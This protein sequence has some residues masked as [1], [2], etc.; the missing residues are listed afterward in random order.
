[1]FLTVGGSRVGARAESDVER[2]K[3]DGKTS[4]VHFVHFDFAPAEIAAF[5]DASQQIIVG[6]DHHEYSHMAVMPPAVREALAQDFG[7]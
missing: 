2:T 1:M 3:A 6:I 5:R 7:P 4:S